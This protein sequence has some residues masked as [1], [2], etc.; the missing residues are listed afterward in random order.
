[1]KARVPVPPANPVVSVSNASRC[2]RLA[3]SC[4]MECSKLG[5]FAVPWHPTLEVTQP[6]PDLLAEQ[7]TIEWPRLALNE[8]R[9][10]V[11]QLAK[12]DDDITLCL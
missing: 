8:R 11:E 1:M 5:A 6:W 2:S 4:P 9:P 3:V 12:L 7:V 10:Q